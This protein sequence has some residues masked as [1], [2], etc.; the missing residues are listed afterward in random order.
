M[1]MFI[2]LSFL[3]MSTFTEKNINH[4]LIMAQTY[5]TMFIYTVNNS[6]TPSL[7][8]LGEFLHL[9]A[10]YTLSQTYTLYIHM[11]TG[12]QNWWMVFQSK[13]L[14]TQRGWMTQMQ[15]PAMF[16]THPHYALFTHPGL[17]GPSALKPCCLA[18]ASH[19]GRLNDLNTQ[20][21]MFYCNWS[22]FYELQTFISQRQSFGLL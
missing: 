8:Q 18:L 9:S 11:H 10:H 21:H 14:S 15:L 16:S 22:V 1:S 12:L 13:Q 2:S 3:L 5:V 6:Q 19:S 7:L 17:R 4:L 20:L